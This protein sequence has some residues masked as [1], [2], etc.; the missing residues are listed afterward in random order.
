MTLIKKITGNTTFLAIVCCLLWSSAFAGIKIGLTYT[1]P[2]QFAGLRFF[3]SGLMI[4]PFAGGLSKVTR[5]TKEFLKPIM[6]L[7]FL[8]PIFHYVL[9]YAAL[10]WCDLPAAIVAIVVGTGPL[11]VSIAAHIGLKNDKLSRAKLYSMLLG[12]VG[13]VIVTVGGGKDTSVTTTTV[14]LIIGVVLLLITNVNSG[15]IN[16]FIKRSKTKIPSRTL[17]CS[18]MLIGGAVMYLI[19]I[20]FEGVNSLIQ[21]LEYY[22]AL[23]WLSSVSALTF[24]VWFTI[25]QK[26]N[27]KISDINIWKFLVP[28]SGATLSWLLLPN[29]HPNTMILIGMGITAIAL[30]WMNF[31]NRREAKTD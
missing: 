7:T 2:I 25:L 29:E 28:I 16:V 8:R 6:F 10:S 15:V 4:L 24:T 17:S 20:P 14:N 9:F 23:A 26:D 30:L 13:M 27:V 11:F 22:L 21:P 1:P 31:T 12:V 18:S 19:A 3:I 5:E